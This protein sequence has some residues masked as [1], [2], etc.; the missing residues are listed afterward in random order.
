MI[1][2]VETNFLMSIATGRDSQANTLLENPTASVQIAIPSICCMEALSALEDE[3]KRRN[4]FMN[5]LN[6]QI[7]QLRR[8]VTSSH[9]QSLLSHLEQSLIENEALLNDV[10]TRLFQ[11]LDRLNTKAEIIPLTG[12]MLQASLDTRFINKDPTDNLILHC[13]LNHAR[14]HTTDRKVFLSANVKEFNPPEVQAALRDAGADKY[15]SRTQ[16]FL[17]WL[18]SQ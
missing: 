14:L 2:Y 6:I 1:L 7:S 3:V 12:D 10:E 4:R 8:D 15:F 9:A 16:D 17:G 5:E 11:A 13:I 18:E